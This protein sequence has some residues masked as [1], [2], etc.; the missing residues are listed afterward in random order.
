MW[1]HTE[2]SSCC[3]SSTFLVAAIDAA[4]GAAM[5]GAILPVVRPSITPLTEDQ[6]MTNRPIRLPTLDTSNSL[7]VGRQPEQA[8]VRVALAA[9]MAGQGRV[10]LIGG[11][12]GIGKTTL[13]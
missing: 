11:E 1:F 9:A 10:L 7:M 8:H 13:V 3:T 12:A 5:G 6:V 2:L 4:T